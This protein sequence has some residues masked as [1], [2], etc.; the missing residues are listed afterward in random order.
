MAVLVG[1]ILTE[2]SLSVEGVHVEGGTKV[3]QV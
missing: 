1:Q 3:D 2:G